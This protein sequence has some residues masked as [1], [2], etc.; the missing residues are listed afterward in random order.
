MKK[1]KIKNK[2]KMMSNYHAQK[3][4]DNMNQ[5]KDCVKLFQFLEKINYKK[6]KKKRDNKWKY[7]M[8]S[9]KEN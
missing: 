1:V 6:I 9:N 3:K 4:I 5:M 7:N 8:L 2:L